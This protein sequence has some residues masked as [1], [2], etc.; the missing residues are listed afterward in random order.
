M[1][2][3]VGDSVTPPCVCS[4]PAWAHFASDGMCF[5]CG[6]SFYQADDGSEAGPLGVGMT[7]YKGRYQGPY[8]LTLE[9]TTVTPPPAPVYA[10]GGCHIA[11]NGEP[12]CPSCGKDAA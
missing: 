5:E 4:D 10:C 1:S 2:A 9:E 8:R 3:V 11:W 6:C 7:P 12:I